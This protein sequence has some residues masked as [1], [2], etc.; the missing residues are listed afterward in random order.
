MDVTIRRA[1]EPDRD[2]VVAAKCS[3]HM[4]VV[5]EPEQRA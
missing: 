5:K 2:A 1:L 4:R 3:E